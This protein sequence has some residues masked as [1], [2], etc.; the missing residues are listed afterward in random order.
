M[1]DPVQ[2]QRDAML[3]VD[4]SRINKL[5][6][7]LD[8]LQDEAGKAM[9]SAL[10]VSGRTSR[11]L[12]KDQI[13]KR[14]NMQTAYIN[15][16]L[17]LIPATPAKPFFTIRGNYRGTLLTRFSPNPGPQSVGGEGKRRRRLPGI[18]VVVKGKASGGTRKRLPGAFYLRLRRGTSDGEGALGIAIRGPNGKAKVLHGPSPHQV[19]NQIKE[20][21]KPQ[22]QEVLEKNLDR[23]LNFRLKRWGEKKL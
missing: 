14:V 8:Q 11:N 5:V 15:K 7:E 3:N 22:M 20:D 18:S 19:L 12:A 17:T 9:R 16:Y 10:A 6:R 13:K 2:W 21:L 1:S 4:F 23:E